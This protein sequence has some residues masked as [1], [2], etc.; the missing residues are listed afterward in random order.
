MDKSSKNILEVAIVKLCQQV[1]ECKQTT[2]VCLQDDY[3]EDR[4]SWRKR[5]EQVK[6]NGISWCAQQVMKTRATPQT[7]TAGKS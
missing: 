2:L 7:S 3:A 5:L 4:S 6:K 1:Y